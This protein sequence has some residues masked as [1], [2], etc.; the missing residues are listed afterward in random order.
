[1]KP[2]NAKRVAAR[3]PAEAGRADVGALLDQGRALHGRGRLGE[4]FDCYQAAMRAAP[5]DAEVL[6]LIGVAYL[7]LGQPQLGLAFI[8]RA[9]ARRPGAAD[10]HVNLGIEL[11]RQGQ[12]DEAVVELRSACALNPHDAGARAELAALLARLD[13]PEE[14]E[15]GF[16][17]AIALD[18]DH[19]GW[20][21]ALA[22]LRYRRWAMS[23]AMQSAA[24]AFE[25]APDAAP[26]IG[27]VQP[28][29]VAPRSSAAALIEPVAAMTASERERACAD[30]ELLV[31]DDFLADPLLVRA[32]ALQLCERQARLLPQVNFPGIQTPPQP[33]QATMQRIA[34]LL[35][36]PLK[37]DSPDHGALRISLANDEARNDVHVDSPT[38]PH[39]FGG[40]LHLSLP[41]H[42]RGG[43]RFYRHRATG[44]D[45]RP[46]DAALRAH[47]DASFLAF[48]KRHLPGPRRLPFSEW[49][50]QREAVWECLF[51]V[52]ARFNRLVVFRSD[53]FHAITELFGDRPENGR[54]V[55]LFHFESP[56]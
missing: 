37:W 2:N 34:D 39:I 6:H 51:E 47:G 1:M 18:A 8:R 46:D 38:L 53:F 31:I 40:V 25:L 29:A 7:G 44:W 21:L 35:G 9:I 15:R 54:L 56:G 12:F 45:R 19:A 3:I 43:T 55:Q 49:Q 30:R 5:D 50:R 22:R 28:K 36:R 24:R 17:S 4:A 10:Y 42:A 14:A 27:W 32:E 16:E 13:R 20:H 11:A 23:E 33:C 48:Q 41:E 52:P 26:N